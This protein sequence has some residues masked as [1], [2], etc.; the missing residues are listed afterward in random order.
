MEI[1]YT[2][3]SDGEDRSTFH[4]HRVADDQCVGTIRTYGADDDQVLSNV[5]LRRSADVI[6]RFEETSRG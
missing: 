3:W 5:L 4:V 6:V 2:L 1:E